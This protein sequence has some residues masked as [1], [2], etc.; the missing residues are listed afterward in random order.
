MNSYKKLFNNSFIFAVGR[1]GS[2]LISVLLVPIY[3]YYLSTTE[4]GTVDLVITTVN[5]FLP[6]VSV[7][8]F[9]A[10]LRFVMDEKSEGN[11]VLNNALFVSMVG[12]L[13]SLLLLPVIL[14]SGF[15]NKKSIVIYMYL[16]LFTNIIERI[17][18]EFTRSIGRIK[19][20]AI[21]GILLTFLIGI[22]NILFLVVFKTGVSGYFTSMILANIISTIYLCYNL[23]NS[24]SLKFSLLKI[25]E[26]K[27]L[28][29]YSVPLIPNTIMWW[30]I[31]A[32]SRY[33]I[34]Y[35]VGVSSNGLF[36]VASRIPTLINLI[37]QIFTQAWQLS[38][39]EEYESQ[40][41]SSFY[42]KVFNYLS[43]IMLMGVGV[44]LVGLKPLFIYFFSTEYFGS[45]RT[46]PFLLL[47]AVFS[48]FSGFLGTNYVASKETKGVFKTSVYGG[49]LSLILNFLL[50][51]VWGIIGAGI[52]SM[53]SFFTMWIIRYFDT[54]NYVKMNIDWKVITYNVGLVFLQIIVLWLSMEILIE[55]FILL[56]ILFTQL[57]INKTYISN[58][59]MHSKN[60]FV[61]IIKKSR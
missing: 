37:N 42:S 33:F 12:F 35:F 43:S 52:S 46:V 34:T 36:A 22:L 39:I 58:I 44:L 55:T 25:D 17:F 1:L 56:M 15:Q 26:M 21:N 19:V 27:V 59:Y 53:C 16:L 9:E 6:I 51:P 8:M 29:K 31:N 32:S 11:T 54:K 20:F 45:W 10:V 18:S 3:T 49:L 60:I 61:N 7:S 38:A 41:K 14:Y 24:I 30:L 2:S 13:I 40:D 4:F 47:G 28:I 23:R 50:I 5:M 57:F 48:C